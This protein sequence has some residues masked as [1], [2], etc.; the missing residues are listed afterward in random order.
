M[1]VNEG[2]PDERTLIGADP[3][4]EDEEGTTETGELGLGSLET[5]SLLGEAGPSS[6]QEVSGGVTAETEVEGV[7]IP[8]LDVGEEGAAG[9][10]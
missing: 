9:C 7:W 2:T 10:D 5:G 6:V 1:G 8:S 3:G 4:P